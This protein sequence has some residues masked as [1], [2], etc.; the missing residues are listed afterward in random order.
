MT[1]IGSIGGLSLLKFVIVRDKVIP[2]LVTRLLVKVHMGW[3]YNM[4]LGTIMF[5]QCFLCICIDL[6]LVVLD[7]T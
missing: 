7:R 1:S 5:L 2:A 3:S 4:Y 6:F